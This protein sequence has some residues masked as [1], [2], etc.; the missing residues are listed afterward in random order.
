[1]YNLKILLVVFF[2]FNFSV[3]AQE[4]ENN[5]NQPKTYIGKGIEE[6]DKTLK[7]LGDWWK[8]LWK[9]KKRIEY[10][11]FSKVE[12]KETKIK[13]HKKPGN[14]VSVKPIVT[15]SKSTF[16]NFEPDLTE[17]SKERIEPSIE[18]RLM[19]PNITPGKGYISFQVG[20]FRYSRYLNDITED[21]IKSIKLISIPKDS[22]KIADTC[23]VK[24]YRITKN[25]KT[26]RH[27]SFVL[28]HSGSMGNSRADKLQLAVLKAV[29]NDFDQNITNTKYSVHKFDGF[30]KKLVTSNNI[31]DIKKVLD[32]QNQLDGFGG[33]TALFTALNDGIDNIIL[34]NDS[35]SK[36]LVLFTDGYPNTDKTVDATQ[37]ILKALINRVNVVVIGF[38]AYINEKLLT[39][40]ARYAGGNYYRIYHE[41]EFEQLYKN[42]I[43]DVRIS[44][45]VEFSPCM[46]GD[47]MDIQMEVIVNDEPLTGDAYF[48]S[49]ADVG[50]S[51]A[52]DIRF[53]S[54]SYKINLDKYK[55]EIDQLLKFLNFKSDL[56]IL[57]EGHTDK[58]GSEK[59]NQKISEK[60][61]ESLK[62]ILVSKGIDANRISTVG[63]GENSSAFSYENGEE[64]NELNRRIEIKIL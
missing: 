55:F 9:G 21:D 60:R 29:E 4:I 40:I 32:P 10:E 25:I 45:D 50:N 13:K 57:I 14:Y 11:L 17:R 61:A 48:R 24:K 56:D 3:N 62:K 15:T 12:K 19:Y 41:N 38:G 30:V 47:Q 37:V 51:I 5:Q 22:S 2:V 6:L 35:N 33:S 53:E 31:N 20:D 54:G 26:K 49:P 28:D 27:F 8:K 52:I 43:R 34:D 1:M 7:G 42:V 23:Y 58:Q 64:E 46:F 39:D 18:L 63:M 36:I 16:F 44:Y 59:I